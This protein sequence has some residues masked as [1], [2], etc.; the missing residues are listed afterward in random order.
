MFLFSQ[1]RHER[2]LELVCQ[3]QR[4]RG[5]LP[6]G[7]DQ[8]ADRVYKL[9]I[10]RRVTIP[11]RYRWAGASR[12]RGPGRCWSRTSPTTRGTTSSTTCPAPAASSSGC[13]SSPR[14][15]W[16][17]DN[18]GKIFVSNTNNIL[19]GNI[20]RWRQDQCQPVGP[21]SGGPGAAAVSALVL[22]ACLLLSLY[23]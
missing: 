5:G 3:H 16:V 9:D 15:R 11:P 7:A 2:E 19:T 14:P 6:R 10:T 23:T 8:G 17:G 1:G 20:R 4:G 18:R 12:G 22:A 13:A 21:F